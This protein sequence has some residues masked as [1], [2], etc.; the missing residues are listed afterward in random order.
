MIDVIQPRLLTDSF[1]NPAVKG[2]RPR[3]PA[4]ESYFSNPALKDVKR[5]T[6]PAF[7]EQFLQSSYK[8]CY[9]QYNPG[10]DRQFL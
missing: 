8:G 9:K 5:N 10:F 7:G 2:I 4:L 6:F 1:Y 3:T